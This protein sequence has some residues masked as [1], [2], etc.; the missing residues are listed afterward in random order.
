MFVVANS[1]AE[2]NKAATADYNQRVVECRL[3]S[4]VLAKRMRLQ[5]RRYPTLHQLQKAV[6]LGVRHLR[7]LA[8]ETLHELPYTK[9]EVRTNDMLK[10]VSTVQA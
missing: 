5:W 6:G 4:Y 1:L 8:C 7:A 9:R 3:V 2:L 10:I